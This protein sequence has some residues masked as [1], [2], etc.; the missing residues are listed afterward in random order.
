VR[1]FVLAIHGIRVSIFVAIGEEC[2]MNV[3]CG[4]EEEGNFCLFSAAFPFC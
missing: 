3:K 2:K 4:I 1:I